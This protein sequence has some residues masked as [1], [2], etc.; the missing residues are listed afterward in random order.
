MRSTRRGDKLRS[1]IIQLCN[2]SLDSCLLRAELLN[3]LQ[4][5][6]PFD[7]AY[8][9][10]TDP[11]T[12]LG[13]GT[14]M[15]TPPPSWVMGMFVENEFLQTDVNSFHAMWRSNRPVA[16]L[17]DATGSAPA[18][19][20]RYRDMLMPLGMT[21]ELRA[22]FTT[23]SAC[24]GTLCL[25]RQGLAYTPTEAGFVESVAGYIADGLRKAYVLDSVIRGVAPRDH[26][27][28]IVT[29]DLTITA[30]TAAVEYWLSELHDTEHSDRGALPLA[31]RSVV[32]HLIRLER[33]QSADV[34]P[35]ARLRI[36]SGHW[37]TLSASR[38]YGPDTR[39]NIAVM[40]APAQP[41]EL[42]PIMMQAYGLSRRESE[43]TLCVVRGWSTIKIA[44]RLHISPLTVQDHLKAL[45]AKVD[46]NSRGEL[47]A[48][49]FR[50]QHR[51]EEIS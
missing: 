5:A 36:G 14:V 3:R 48:R 28:L 24:W 47:A 30:Q 10:V 49:I 34:V 11:V 13:V 41:A 16:T 19:S 32:G 9:T 4:K 31:V 21:D 23:D 6:V 37:L 22:V 29:E 44:Q 1:E 43:I 18:Q 26:G 17:R 15:S 33:G 8:F 27:V 42:A 2:A 46:V 20:P 39:P 51:P 35:A 12:G 25:H 40:L 50:Q 45:F 38:L 7:Y